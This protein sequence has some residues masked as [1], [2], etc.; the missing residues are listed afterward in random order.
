LPRFK[1]IE[2][3]HVMWAIASKNT[4][5]VI[6]DKKNFFS[7]NQFYSLWQLKNTWGSLY[8][9]KKVSKIKY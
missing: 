6:F 2:T 5:K 8:H 1:N 9:V 4:P 3:F 7:S